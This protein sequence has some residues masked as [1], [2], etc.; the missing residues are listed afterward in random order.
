M[1]EQHAVHGA[2]NGAAM[3][4]AEHRGVHTS[5]MHA[6]V[7][8]RLQSAEARGTS[9]A[10]RANEVKCELACMRNELESSGRLE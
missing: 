1:L 6:T 7:E 5:E 2:D 9:P 10:S 8:S 4:K 3:A